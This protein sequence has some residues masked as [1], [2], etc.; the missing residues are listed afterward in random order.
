MTFKRPVKGS[1]ETTRGGSDAQNY[2]YYDTPQIKP[3]INLAITDLQH[4]FGTDL[5]QPAMKTWSV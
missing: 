1:G 4:P 5:D 3:Q 2:V